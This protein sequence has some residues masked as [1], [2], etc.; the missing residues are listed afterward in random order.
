MTLNYRKKSSKM[1][2]VKVSKG[3]NAMKKNVFGKNSFNQ[4]VCKYSIEN[5]NGMKAVLTDIGAAVVEL[6]VKDQN[7]TFRDV[8]LGYDEV[9]RYEKE[10]TYFGAIVGRYA[11]RISGAKIEIDDIVYDLDANDNENTLHSGKDSMAKKIW[12]VKEHTENRIVFT[13]TS[14]ELEE[15]FPGTV[16]CDVTYEVTENNAL[17]ISYYAVSD[18]KTALNMTNHTYF[19]L[20]GHDAGTILGHELMIK[21]SGYTPVKDSK[22][23][24]TGEIAKVEG[25]PFDFRAPKEIGRD[26]D[27]DFEQLVFG[28]GYDH[29]FVIEKEHAGVEKFAEAYSKD[30]GIQMEVWTDCI[31][32]QF[33]TGNFLDGDAGK[34]GCNYVRRGG[35]CLETQFFPNAINEPNFVRPIVEANAPY[36]TKTVYKFSVR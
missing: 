31:G 16:V 18:K 26:I 4:D 27:D 29:N 5:E 28:Q 6:W 23:I 7:G 12:S 24:P 32:V 17:E 33:Y 36:E 3:E 22:S 30:S 1:R 19:N 34:N 25:T 21:A 2:Y 13:Y 10:G 11:N 14:K 35:F 20:N 9:E 15:G 8:A